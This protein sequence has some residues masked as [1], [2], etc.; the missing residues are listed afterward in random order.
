MVRHSSKSWWNSHELFKA[1]PS[2]GLHSSGETSHKQW[3]KNF[4]KCQAGIRN[5]MEQ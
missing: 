2:R 3:D 4:V 5:M 1:L